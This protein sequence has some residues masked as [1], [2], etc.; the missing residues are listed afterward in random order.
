MSI[1]SRRLSVEGCFEGSWLKNCGANLSEV[2]QTTYS[3]LHFC[4]RPIVDMILRTYA[5]NQ[6][7]SLAL[8]P[9]TTLAVLLAAAASGHLEAYNAGFPVDYY[10]ADWYKNSFTLAALSGA[11]ILGGAYLANTVFN[12]HEFFNVPVFV[13]AF[14]YSLMGATLALIQLS[15]PVLVANVFVL[16]GLNKHLKIFHQ[17]RV[18][19]EYFETGFWY[20]LA[21]VCFPPY[22]ALAAAIWAGSIITRAFHWR[23]YLLPMV[24]FAVPFG[25]W[26]SWLYFQ[27]SMD[28]MVLFRKWVSFDRQSYF[29]TWD[30][31]YWTFGAIALG[32]L[33][34]ALPRYLFLSER[35]SNKAKT[36]RT[37]FFVVAV[38]L[39]VS[40][41][42]AYILIWQWVVMALLLPVAFLL[43]YWFANYRVSLVAPFFFYALLAT[44]L[45]C[46]LTVI[47]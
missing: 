29:S 5:S 30:T 23:E 19:A 6:P 46:V 3:Y 44:S 14:T 21:A 31:S 22:L 7:L 18:L 16:L 33:L 47:I 4:C 34:F 17:P 27:D 13:P 1:E 45:W 26:L 40:Y 9:I 35:S 2:V 42:A 28:G 25:Y 38:A 32:S 37:I 43:G 36:I 39:V 10:L 41:F 12:R 8:L 20:G 11:L 24:A 15:V